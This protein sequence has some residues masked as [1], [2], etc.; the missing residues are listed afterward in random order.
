MPQLIPVIVGIAATAAAAEFSVAAAVGGFLGLSSATAIGAIAS[1]IG[2]IVSLST[3]LVIGAL[4]PT[5]KAAPLQAN[6]SD[7]T[8]LFRTAIAARPVVYGQTLVSGQMVYVGSSGA[9]SRYLHCVVLLADHPIQSVD[10]VWINDTRIDAAVWDSSGNVVSGT[11]SG[12][13]RVRAYLGAQTAA[14]S[15]LLAEC[16][17]VPSSFVGYGCSYLYVR[18]LADRDKFASSLQN[19]A[20]EVHGKSDIYDPRDASTGYTNNWALCVRD[21]LVS[22]F[23][24]ACAADELDDASFI[25]A[26]NI[27]AEAVAIN[28]GGTDTQARYTCDGSF[29]LDSK[30]IDIL[31]RLLTAGA[32]ALTY[33][34]GRHRLHAGAYEAPSDSLD[35]S[36]MAGPVQLIT[37]RPGREIYNALRGTFINP[38][39]RWQAAAFPAVYSSTYDAEDGE[40]IWSSVEL[41]FTADSTRAQR[42][43]TLMLK[44]SRY[45]M[46]IKVPVKYAALR[47]AVKQVLAVDIPDFGF[48]AKPFEVSGWSFDPA[49]GQVS[50]VLDETAAAAFTWAYDAAQDQP[51]TLTSTLANPLAIPAPTSLAVTATTQI[52][53]DG[54]AAPALL[55]TWGTPA[56]P[57]LQSFEVQWRTGGGSPG[58]WNSLF[59][60]AQVARA[61]LAPVMIG[62]AYDV[63]VRA[64]TALARGAWS[65]TVAGTG[66]ADTTAP[67]AP[68]SLAV[69][70]ILRGFSLR[71][72]KATAPDLAVTEV[73]ENT[74]GTWYPIGETA[75]SSFIRQGFAPGDQAYHRLRSRDL[76]GNRSGYTSVVGPTTVPAAVTSDISP[77]A[78]SVTTSTN[79]SGSISAA[80]G[81]YTGWVTVASMT[82]GASGQSGQLLV[83]F[84]IDGGALSDD[85]LVQNGLQLLLDGSA[86][87]ATITR[88][89]TKRAFAQ[90]SITGAHT[91]TLE[92]YAYSASSFYSAQVTAASMTATFLK[93]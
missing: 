41:P 29:L 93:R 37:A 85:F 76:S 88:D 55:V 52:Q 65:S 10:A 87:A 82:V 45:Q 83:N 68:T 70:G 15:D 53:A 58:P 20:A 74:A 23:G 64:C 73:E 31:T 3:S 7:R 8:G 12:L 63:R 90:A 40:R 47:F 24:M 49:S 17:E 34:Q 75:G 91:L 72:I 79:W 62:G 61:V 4:T 27:S 32:G 60:D 30:R 2:M 56:F 81:G 16:P 6:Q 39:D 89:A 57:F 84:G 19:I 54:G 25:A 35:T 33:V 9:D 78:V 43:A 38:A 48:S 71:W 69:L 11:L 77:G 26:A 5:K 21:Y 28:A 13:V 44:R 92:V 51:V 42:I 1:A 59:T 18:L 86:L 66:A 36:D 50:L 67:S 14:D 22:S 46:Q 80:P